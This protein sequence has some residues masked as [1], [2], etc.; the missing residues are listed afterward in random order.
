V[1]PDDVIEQVR[2]SADLVDLIGEVVS[3]KRTGADWRGPCPFHGGTHR[4][5]AVIPKKGLYY[6]Y[7]C[8][9]GGDVFTFLM[10]RFGMDYPTAVR[11]VARRVGIAIP[12]RGGR[13]G[14]DPREPLFSAAAVAQEWFAAR[15]REGP[16]ADAARTYLES[17]ELPLPIAAELGLGYAPSDRSFALA[18]LRFAT[19]AVEWSPSAAGFSARASRNT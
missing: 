7:V 15:L 19:S 12:E 3:L 14:P 4:N 1:I 10:K 11:E 18:M 6:C 8:H 13:E 5:F 17:R 16:D 9:E 2:D